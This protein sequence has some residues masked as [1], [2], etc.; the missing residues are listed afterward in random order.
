M[1]QSS[2]KQGST[3]ATAQVATAEPNRP[4]RWSRLNQR[5]IVEER[6]ET[7]RAKRNLYL[8]SAILIG[9][10]LVIFGILLTSV[11]SGGPLTDVDEPI[12]DWATTSRSESVTGAMVALSLFFGPLIF[13]WASLTV[14]VV[15]SLTAKHL[16]R[17]LLLAG[18]IL[19]G[20]AGVRL[21]AL[22]VGRE[23][24]PL[25]DMLMEKDYSESFPSGH[26]VGASAFILLIAYLVF[27]RRKSTVNTVVAFVLAAALVAATAFSRIYLGYHWTTDA[28]GSV[29]LALVILGVVMAIDTARTVRVGREEPD[30]LPG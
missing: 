11:L 4:G 20:V 24:P 19:V 9:A 2:M 15:W 13:P 23:R 27:S 26:V 10:G 22:L 1:E 5:F 28:V 21:L 17:P 3:D 8:I 18:G 30:A 16:W 12:A 7:A 6:Q 25:A 29:G 14:V